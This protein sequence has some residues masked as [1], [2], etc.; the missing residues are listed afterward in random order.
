MTHSIGQ[1]TLMIQPLQVFANLSMGFITGLASYLSLVHD[2]EMPPD[3]FTF[4]AITN[5]L[6]LMST[7]SSILFILQLTFGRF[8]SIIRP[9]KAASFNT[10]KKAK[11]TIVII[12]I[13]SILFN[14]PPIFMSANVGKE[15]VPWG[16]GYG[17]SCSPVALLCNI[18]C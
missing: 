3:H 14:I 10:V 16:E 4:C 1:Y 11:I 15:C 17:E 8:Y 13:P 6:L 2:I 5:S 12:A 9:H 7:T 18:Y